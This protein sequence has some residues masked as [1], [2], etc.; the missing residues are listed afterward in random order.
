MTAVNG[1]A[2]APATGTTT[3]STNA[4]TETSSTTPSGDP[5]DAP[6]P[7]RRGPKSLTDKLV[8]LRTQHSRALAKLAEREVMLAGQL[9]DVRGKMERLRTELACVDTSLGLR[10]PEL[11]RLVERDEL[12]EPG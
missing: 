4:T 8:E 3:T 11:P 12:G 6:R 2:E 1:H 9:D 5:P 10:Q 7:P